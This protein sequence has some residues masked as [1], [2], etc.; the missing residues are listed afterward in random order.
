MQ[1][2]QL[3]PRSIPT[4]DLSHLSEADY[5]HVYEPAEDSF[6]MLDA[7]ESELDTIRN[8]KPNICMEIGCGTGIILTALA[9]CLGPSVLYVGTDIN[10]EASK[11]SRWTGFRN[12]VN[13]EVVNCDLIIPFTERLK[14]IV[15]II[16]FNPPYVPTEEVELNSEDPLVKS[17]AGGRRGRSVMD[18]LFPLIPG[19]LSRDGIFYLLIVRENDE[20]DLILT[21]HSIGLVVSSVVIERRAGRE[22]LKILKFQLCSRNGQ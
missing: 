19:I 12:N 15:D 5:E 7:L 20:Q 18:R 17:W 21:M 1:P 4:P 2:S 16:I 8:L 22:F 10:G 9:N 11:T 6:L 14:N 13:L 3:A